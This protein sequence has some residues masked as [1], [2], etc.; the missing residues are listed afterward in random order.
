VPAALTDAQKAL[1]AF[2]FVSQLAQSIPELRGYLTQASKNGWTPELLKGTIESSPWW[3][4]HADTVRQLAITQATDPA[5][6]AQTLQ[7][8]RNRV[9]MAAQQLGRTYTGDQLTQLALQTLTTNAG[10]D[11]GVLNQ[12]L[13]NKLDI[14][15]YEDGREIGGAA[16][17]RNHMTTVAESYGQPVTDSFLDQFTTSI[18]AGRDSLAGFES[19]M[20]ARAKAHYPQFADQIDAGMTVRDVADPYI[21]T[22]ANTLEM[23]ETAVTLKDPYVSKALTVRNP[24]GSAGVQPLWQF[25]RNLKDDPRYA[26]TTQ[27][28]TDAYQTLN[29]IGKDWGFA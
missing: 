11:S 10:W 4:Q 12:L 14:G 23:P 7:N 2:G 1:E 28:K 8:A 27:A 19:L 24:D 26:S 20:R 25:E 6:Y 13:A 29:K 18:Q 22:M 15:H 21:R 9:G 3:R 17:T 5:T 16:E